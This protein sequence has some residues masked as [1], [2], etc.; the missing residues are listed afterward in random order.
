MG[1]HTHVLG[2]R[3]LDGNVLEG[4]VEL[5]HLHEINKYLQKENIYNSLKSQV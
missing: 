5:K 3:H 2:W 1:V 4:M